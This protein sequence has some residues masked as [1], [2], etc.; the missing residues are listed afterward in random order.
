MNFVETINTSPFIL[1][2]GAVIERLNR[3]SSIELDP[4]I[5]HAGL[6]YE[7]SGRMAL[8]KIYRQYIDIGLKFN[9]PI[10]LSAPTW[11]ANPERIAASRYQQHTTINADGVQ[12][13]Q[14]IRDDYAEYASLIFIAGMMACRGDSYRPQEALSESDAGEFHKAQA[15]MLAASGVDLIMAATLPAVSEARGIATAI[16]P[17]KIPY[18]VSFV[19][20]SDGA[21]LDGTPLHS[22]I[23]QIDSLDQQK[24]IIYLVNCVHPSV[25]GQGL[26]V[27][28][29][30]SKS[31]RNRLFGL[32]ANTSARSPEELDGLE[33]LDG[34]EPIGFAKELLALHY[35]FGIKVIGGCCGTDHRHIEEIAARYSKMSST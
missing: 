23:D 8:E 13:M 21:L 5:L 28:V 22:A 19:I 34:A 26:A 24:P 2:E 25:F 16:A 4:Q 9:F 20:R 15:A 30:A 10:L 14:S 17:L 33:Q 6:I 29:E 3:D 7:D 1:T 12:F 18:V 27:E 32:Q 35:K 11:R 31:I